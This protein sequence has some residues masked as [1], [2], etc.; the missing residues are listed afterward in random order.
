MQSSII[1]FIAI[2]VFL[3][4]YL[5][6]IAKDLHKHT[7]QNEEIKALLEKIVNNQLKN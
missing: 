3:L 2:T 6:L 5:P 7:K 4:Y 1:F